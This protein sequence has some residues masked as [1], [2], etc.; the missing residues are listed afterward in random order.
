MTDVMTNKPLRLGLLSTGGS[1]M[2]LPASQLDAVRQ[3][4]DAHGVTYWVDDSQISFDGGPYL[5]YIHV[6]NRTAPAKV[7]ALLDSVP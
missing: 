5:A 1:E 7:Q 4:L 2:R 3:L 6:S